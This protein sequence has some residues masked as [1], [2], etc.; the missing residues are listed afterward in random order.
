MLAY[1]M[2]YVTLLLVYIYLYRCSYLH[3][4]A[5]EC[6]VCC[7]ITYAVCTENQD[8]LLNKDSR[9]AIGILI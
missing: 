1:W 3:F 6:F 8:S 7:N 5:Y 2:T 9:S 4:L